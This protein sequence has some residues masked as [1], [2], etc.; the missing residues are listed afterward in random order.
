MEL[1]GLLGKTLKHSFSGEYF[2][3]KFDKER[4]DAEYRLFEFDDVPDLHAFA[5]DNS[6]LKGLNVTIPFKRKV[7][8]QLDDA[9][10]IVKIT[11]NANVIKIIRKNGHV[12]LVGF[13]TDVRGFE[14]SLKPLV[15]KKNNLRALIL[16]TGGAAHSV[17]FV[18]RKMG[19]YFYFVTRNPKKVEMLGYSWVTPEVIKECQLIVNASP[20]GMF[21]DANACPDIP[22]EN[23]SPEHILFDLIYNPAETCFLK[24]GKESGAILKNGLEML[25]IQADESWK[26]W[27]NKSDFLL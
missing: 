4:I 7:I 21:P 23:L 18:L 16:G 6:S 10:N 3:K 19:I 1:Y 13:N 15:R 8:H 2:G 26:I 12:K 20:I 27:K 25:E 14:R 11:G 17:A 5:K 9:S 22:Y 24:K